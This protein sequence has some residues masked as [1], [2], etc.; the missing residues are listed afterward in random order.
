MNGKGSETSHQPFEDARSA[1]L[2]YRRRGIY[3]IL[4]NRR[5]KGPQT[6]GWPDLRLSL[7]EI[8]DQA[9]PGMNVGILLG[10]PSGG[11]KDVDL[12][13]LEAVSIGNRWLP[14][15]GMRFGRK[16]KRNSHW[17]Y[18]TLSDLR[19]ETFRDPEAADHEKAMIL[20]L[21]GT[22]HQTMA[23]GS[24]HPSGE[25]VEFESFD[26]PTTVDLDELRSICGRVA[27]A[28]VLARHW[29]PGQRH[30]ATL[31][32]AGFLLRHGWTEVETADFLDAMA[33]A[34]GADRQKVAADVQDT[35]N[36][37]RAGGTVTGFP[38]LLS[39]FP[40]RV[41]EKAFEWLRLPRGADAGVVAGAPEQR[42]WIVPGELPSL[43]DPVPALE[44]ELIPEP[45]RDWASDVTDRMRV[46]LEYVAFPVMC[47]VAS[48]VGRS[49]AMRPMA[50]DNWTEVAT[51]WG[52][53]VG[54]PGTLKTPAINAGLRPLYRLASIA[55]EEF[56]QMRRVAEIDEEVRKARLKGAKEKLKDAAKKGLL[57]D[58]AALKKEIAELSA[59][60]DDEATEKRYITNDATTE[61]LGELLRENPRGLLVL[62][63]ELVG[64][65]ESFDRQGREADR[66]F[67][68]EAWNGK[69]SFYI[70]RIQRGSL[71]VPALTLSVFGGIQPDR[72]KTFFAGAMANGGEMDGLLQRFQLI[73][74]PDELGEFKIVDRFP[75]GDAADRAFCVFRKLDLL[76]PNDVG[77]QVGDEDELP[78][79]RFSAEAQQCF[80]S[81]YEP[82]MGRV[83]SADA[84]KTPGFTAHLAKYSSLLT[85]LAFLFHLVE[86]VDGRT[87]G[88]V[89]M[90]A[91]KRAVKWTEYLELHARK[92]YA[93]EIKGNVAAAYAL[94][95]KIR[96]GAVSDRMTVRDVWRRE[97]SGLRSSG[98]VYDAL[99]VLGQ[100]GWTRIEAEETGGR[101][102]TIIRVNPKLVKESKK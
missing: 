18:V 75:D 31:P 17:E 40:E 51:L 38:T 94:G 100:I 73:A 93:I 98:Q 64:W 77:A 61:K 11:L 68:L 66:A 49:I 4:Y 6:P 67:Y 91:V 92:V 58:F 89:G 101:D 59:E 5:E 79:L 76:K 22:G 53:L 74:F 84:Q 39:Y 8:A 10:E 62:R 32:L 35:A 55:S 88:P 71:F 86:T 95:E 69:G 24:V 78:F 34:V 52:A 65:L 23:P 19:R 82:L 72:L 96:A 3:P 25:P 36:R 43:T 60:A 85:K 83:R 81:W 15:T 13:W 87:S 90:D 29:L 20:E 54:G 9:A 1:A 16:S 41:L 21:R 2:Q 99:E 27:A 48:V 30:D 37:L 33:E 14:H 44:P 80:Y 56:K 42:T 45:L 12:D 50:C 47:A 57:N 63:D 7:E 26:D 97:W 70:D 102:R 46:P 28:A